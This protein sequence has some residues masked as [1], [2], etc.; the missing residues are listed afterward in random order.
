M[1]NSNNYTS[2]IVYRISPYYFDYNDYSYKYIKFQSYSC[3]DNKN[4]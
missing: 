3:D 1:Y 2:C 4:K